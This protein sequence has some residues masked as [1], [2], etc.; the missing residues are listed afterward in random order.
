MPVRSCASD[1]SKVLRCSG[2][3]RAAAEPSSPLS[4]LGEKVRFLLVGG[5]FSQ[6]KGGGLTARYVA[7]LAFT[8]LS[9]LISGLFVCISLLSIASISGAY[10]SLSSPISAG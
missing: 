5:L 3:V 2:S 1:Q 6:M 8:C 10:S 9:A 7:V 4:G